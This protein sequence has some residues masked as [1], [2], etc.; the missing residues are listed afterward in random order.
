MAQH[1]LDLSQVRAVVEQIGGEA[2][3][4]HMGGDHLPDARH[5]RGAEQ[6]P[7]RCLVAER[8]PGPAREQPGLGRAL[9]LVVGPEQ[10]VE[11]RVHGHQPLPATLP[12]PHMDDLLHRVD[13]SGLQQAGLPDPQARGVDQGKED[14]ILGHQEPVEHPLDLGWAKDRGQGGVLPRH[15]DEG[16]LF[17]LAQ[18]PPVEELQRR[19]VAAQP[20]WADGLGLEV[21]HPVPDCLLIRLAHLCTEEFLEASDRRKVLLDGPFRASCHLQIALQAGQR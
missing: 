5:G 7:T 1:D 21:V 2:M 18:R 15:R 9:V 6:G 12:V 4:K 10:P 16:H 11:L 3:P 17:W 19:V 8:L 13:V 20:L 14:P